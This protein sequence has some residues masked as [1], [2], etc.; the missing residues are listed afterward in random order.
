MKRM[1]NT[2]KFFCDIEDVC[3]MRREG[4]NLKKLDEISDGASIHQKC[5]VRIE[6]RQNARQKGRVNSTKTEKAL[7]KSF[8]GWLMGNARV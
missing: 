1:K 5:H 7:S 3:G 8:P 6:M 4:Y 2:F